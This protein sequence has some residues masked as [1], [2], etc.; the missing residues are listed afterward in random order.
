VLHTL[1]TE[2]VECPLNGHRNPRVK[3]VRIQ[4]NGYPVLFRPV[5]SP[6]YAATVVLLGL[7]KKPKHAKER[8]PEPVQ[9]LLPVDETVPG[10]K[11][12]GFGQLHMH[13]ANGADAKP[14]A[15][16]TI[17]KRGTGRGN[18]I[19]SSPDHAYFSPDDGRCRHQARGFKKPECWKRQRKTRYKPKPH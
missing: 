1:Q 17:V 15:S 11:D 3:A 8:R 14:A 4:C 6:L 9:T 5:T 10:K 19:V 16:L 13:F 2:I 12:L 7:H 18:M